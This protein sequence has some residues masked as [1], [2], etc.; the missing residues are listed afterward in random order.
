MQ[1]ICAVKL[2]AHVHEKGPPVDLRNN[3]HICRL[4]L[5]VMCSKRYGKFCLKNQMTFTAKYLMIK[6]FS[7]EQNISFKYDF[8]YQPG[9]V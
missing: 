4:L 2:L 3:N 6:L 1:C 9:T 5:P 8:I 7:L